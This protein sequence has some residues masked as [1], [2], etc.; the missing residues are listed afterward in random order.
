M[1]LS[2]P[3]PQP[4]ILWV[5][6]A[7]NGW[8]EI[9]ALALPLLYPLRQRHLR[10][11]LL[12]RL[13]RPLPRVSWAGALVQSAN[14][15]RNPLNPTAS[16]RLNRALACDYFLVECR[17]LLPGK[18]EA[19]LP[20]P[21]LWRLRLLQRLRVLLRLLRHEAARLETR[22]GTQALEEAKKPGAC[23]LLPRH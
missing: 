19:A 2:M 13:L 8:C 17:L 22:A 4:V 15:S 1:Q 16:R 11:L 12:R 20:A 5:S 6:D 10:L 21:R 18:K 23:L 3:L 9:C 14:C 7:Q